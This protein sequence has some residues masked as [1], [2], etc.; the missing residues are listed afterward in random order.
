[1]DFRPATP[2][3]VRWLATRLEEAGFEAWV[4][5]GAIRDLLLGRHAGDWDFATTARPEEIRA[6]FRRTVPIGLEHGTVGVLA[7]GGVIYHVTTLRRDLRTDGRRAVVEFGDDIEEDLARR[8]FTFNAIAW[9]PT[10]DDLLDPAGG[11]ADIEAGILRTVGD[12]HRRFAEDYLRVLRALRFSGQFDFAIAEETWRAL[13]DAVPRLGTLSAERIQEELMKVLAHSDRPSRALRLYGRSGALAKL[14]PELAQDGEEGLGRTRWEDALRVCD[15]ARRR[16]PL[17]RLAALLS[18][19]A[20]E[21]SGEACAVRARVAGL[22]KR[23]RFSNR[24]SRHLSTLVANRTLPRPKEEAVQIRRWLHRTGP[25]FFPDT[26]R[27]WCAEA[28][29][30]VAPA[31]ASEPPSPADVAGLIRAIRS[32]LSEKPPLAVRDLALDGE[33]LQALG[34]SPGPRFG[35]ILDGALEQVL[36]D[37]RRN[38]RA[39]LEEWVRQSGLLGGVP[40]GKPDP[41]E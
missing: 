8:D 19:L 32:A 1:M 29:A 5:G 4:V 3:A 33:R 30:R 6:T 12:P 20:H 21:D 41:H 34:L 16:R 37:P 35:Q 18:P 28:R 13:C 11:L 39:R 14:Y 9:H 25:E 2:G 36:E 40:D 7:R 15:A 27:V 31:G 26:A 22:T 23:L 38:T 17:V 10:R 24:A